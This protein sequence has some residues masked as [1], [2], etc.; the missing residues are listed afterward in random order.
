[1]WSLSGG[2]VC[3]GVFEPRLPDCIPLQESL[4]Y[5]GA[6]RPFAW[7]SPRASRKCYATLRRGRTSESDDVEL[8]RPHASRGSCFPQAR[9]DIWSS[10]SRA[11]AAALVH[12]CHG[13]SASPGLRLLTSESGRSTLSPCLLWSSGCPSTLL[14]II[15]PPGL[16]HDINIAHNKR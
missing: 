13:P 5:P 15:N 7:S 4:G 3:K 10:P 1:M 2:P 16:L 9:N 11:S 6:P 12:V 14:S 8:R